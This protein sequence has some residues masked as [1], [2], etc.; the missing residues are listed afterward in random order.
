MGDL[1]LIIHHGRSRG[2][3]SNNTSNKLC[4]A[5]DL[6]GM[7]RPRENLRWMLLALLALCVGCAS[8]AS[9]VTE[10]TVT[11]GRLGA[12]QSGCD[13]SDRATPV[14]LERKLEV[15]WALQPG[16]IVSNSQ[17]D[18]EALN[19]KHS[20]GSPGPQLMCGRLIAVI[21]SPPPVD[22]GSSLYQLLGDRKLV[23]IDPASGRVLWKSALPRGAQ[24]ESGPVGREI[25]CA[26]N[27][28][29]VN[30]SYCGYAAVVDASKMPPCRGDV[31]PDVEQGDG[32]FLHYYNLDDGESRVEHRGDLD[33]L[34]AAGNSAVTAA[35]E[36]LRDLDGQIL[37]TRE[38]AGD[39]SIAWTTRVPVNRADQPDWAIDNEAARILPLSDGF[40]QV[41]GGDNES[42]VVAVDS[43]NIVADVPNTGGAH[44]ARSMPGERVAVIRE[45]G[46]DIYNRSG[47]VITHHPGE[48]YLDLTVNPPADD[49]SQSYV[50]DGL[51]SSP[52]PRYQF[53]DVESGQKLP[54]LPTAMPGFPGAPAPGPGTTFG[55]VSLVKSI[56]GHEITGLTTHYVAAVDT[57]TGQVLWTHPG[58][59]IGAPVSA[60]AIDGTI[61]L[62][63]E[64]H[65]TNVG[66]SAVVRAIDIRTGKVL[67]S[68]DEL[69]ALVPIGGQVLGVSADQISSFTAPSS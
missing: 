32:L 65:S 36:P 3:T 29:E 67:W 43:G 62:F 64:P 59:D 10:S 18:V 51:A 11:S 15:G 63:T 58:D 39:G 9:P 17:F 55:R 13:D 1:G 28:A 34:A 16:D 40:I 35:W 42:F 6:P 60:V 41:F 69:A 38:D 54:P 2:A 50:L 12:G 25:V 45:H 27:P 8:G 30:R 47:E 24:C 22:D 20:V 46:I 21:V 4:D 26:V 66:R 19:Q 37:V 48:S 49:G 5:D 44:R 31:A 14:N 56:S 23:A 61:G 33:D 57:F 7:W 68:M 52:L 53:F